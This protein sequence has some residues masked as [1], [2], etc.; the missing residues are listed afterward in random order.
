MVAV[1]NRRSWK[2]AFTVSSFSPTR[3]MAG[4]FRIVDPGRHIAGLDI[5][6]KE[7]GS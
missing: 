1:K 5:Y 2:A 3:V 7:E 6:R 4:R